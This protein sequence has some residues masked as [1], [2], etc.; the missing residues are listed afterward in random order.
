MREEQLEHERKLHEQRLKWQT[1]LHAAKTKMETLLPAGSGNETIK[2]L[3]AKQPKLTIIQF[4][5]SYQDWPRF[6]GQFKI[7][8]DKTGITSITKFAYLRELLGP[9][10]KKSVE[11]LPFS[12][13][14]DN[15][16]K[17]ILGDKYGNESEIIK[18]Y[19]QQIFDLQVISTVNTRKIHEFSE[20]LTYAV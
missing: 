11:A 18:A 8:I 16:A 19:T 2:G 6:W 3:Q 17:S 13:E 15:R 1:E 5:G 7:T 4:N 14:G 10:V 9:K 12:S 20:K